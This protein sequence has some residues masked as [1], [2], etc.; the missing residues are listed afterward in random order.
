MRA[1]DC[2]VAFE[3]SR[4]NGFRTTVYYCPKVVEILAPF[5]ME[6]YTPRGKGD[7]TMDTDLRYD[8]Q[9][10]DDDFAF[11]WRTCNGL[12]ELDESN[13]TIPA[14]DIRGWT[15]F[16]DVVDSMVKVASPRYK[17][18]VPSRIKRSA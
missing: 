18:F 17:R 8:L 2:Y 4:E 1:E 11:I 9:L 3:G 12:L 13:K 16:H 5:I 10:G 6:K 15:T 14:S 7:I